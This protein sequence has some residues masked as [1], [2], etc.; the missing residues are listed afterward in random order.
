VSNFRL[1]PPFSVPTVARTLAT[2][3]LSEQAF[4]DAG[5]PAPERIQQLTRDNCSR[6]RAWLQLPFERPAVLAFI[7]A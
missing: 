1:V 6:L 4:Q 3:D 2:L 7:G 5:R